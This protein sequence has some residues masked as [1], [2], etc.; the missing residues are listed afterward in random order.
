MRVFCG[1]FP[2]R[3][4]EA[5]LLCDAETSVLIRRRLALGK[6]LSAW[7]RLGEG[8]RQGQALSEFSRLLSAI[9]LFRDDGGRVRKMSCDFDL[10]THAHRL[11]QGVRISSQPV[12]LRGH[13]RSLLGSSAPTV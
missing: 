11:L 5:A 9:R 6:S 3:P 2:P 1:D 13:T 7:E 8:E 10:G 4:T 12:T